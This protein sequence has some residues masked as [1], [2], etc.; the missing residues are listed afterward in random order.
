MHCLCNKVA[1]VPIQ[2]AYFYIVD[3]LTSGVPYVTLAMRQIDRWTL[4]FGHAPPTVLCF[5][6]SEQFQMLKNGYV[7]IVLSEK[8]IV[9]LFILVL[10]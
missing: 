4:V 6:N 10:A 8:A 9:S 7:S 3:L 2:H 5:A 1:P